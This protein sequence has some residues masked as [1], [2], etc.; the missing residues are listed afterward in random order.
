[1]YKF[2]IVLEVLQCYKDSV[3]CAEIIKRTGVSKST[4][5]LWIFCYIDDYNKLMN[6]YNKQHKDIKK[7]FIDSLNKDIFTF[8]TEIVNDNP[9][10]SHDKFIHLINQKFNIKL[11]NKK[12]KYILD[13]IN[14]T[15]KHIR[16]RIIK[17]KEFL[18]KIIKKRDEFL[19]IIKNEIID[20]IICI[21]ETG[22]NA[23]FSKTTKGYSKKGKEINIP[24]SDLKLS[25]QSLLMALS[26]NEVIHYDITEENVNADIYLIFMNNL[27]S[28]LKKNENRNFILIFDN[29]R[30]HHDK[31]II[32]LITKNNYKYFF[33][34]PY[35]PNLN[36]IENV[37]GIIK[38]Y[39]FKEIIN[40]CNKTNYANNNKLNKENNKKITIE[41]NEKLKI[42][43]KTKKNIIKQKYKDNIQKNKR[44]KD[45]T[46]EEIEELNK[47]IKETCKNEII[48]VIKIEKCKK[49]NNIKIRKTNCAS[50]I[51]NYVKQ[52]IELFNKN[53]NK[54]R[55]T[56]IYERAFSY[57]YKD[58][59]KELKDR[60]K[61][62]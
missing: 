61:F 36:P 53:Y 12:I 28:K 55:I 47:K 44:L 52:C 41:E 3:P 19:K 4:I 2:N 17:S 45:K 7:I 59:E 62:E 40:N 26:I 16:Q 1:M 56:K 49:K 27:I 60:L 48:E 54:E 6:R 46:K 23:L 13:N 9:F 33:V 14:I 5:Y 18:E 10:M 42:D 20:D 50:T 24:V 43:I 30:F 34:P 29:V 35:S 22:F 39:Y 31:R 15:K 57:D 58:I 37:N 25:N 51:Q 38:D 11:N 8:V 32:D 21:D